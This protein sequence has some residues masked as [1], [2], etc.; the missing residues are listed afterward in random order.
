MQRLKDG[1]KFLDLGCCF[2]QDVRSL[3]Y[4]GAPPEQIWGT[5]LQSGFIELGYELFQDKETLKSHFLAAD[6]LDTGSCLAQLDHTIDVTYAGCFF[7]LFDWEQQ[8]QVAKRIIQLLAAQKGSLV[9]GK[10]VG[11]VTADEKPFQIPSGG[12]VWRHNVASFRRMWEEAAGQSNGQWR[13]NAWLSDEGSFKEA[14]R[15]ADTRWLMFEIERL[16]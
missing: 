12:I 11:H 9:I 7:H 5:D 2:G 4:D 15:D 10:Q 3:V 6:V 16:E 14:W 1:Q 8:V 13:V